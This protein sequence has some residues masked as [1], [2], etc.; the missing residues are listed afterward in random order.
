MLSWLTYRILAYVAGGLGVAVIGLSV[1]L[2]AQGIRSDA[3]LAKKDRDHAQA[4]GKIIKERDDATQKVRA[5]EKLMVDRANQANEKYTK[6]L[7]AKDII[8]AGL[9]SAESHHR[10]TA[11]ELRR[12]LARYVASRPANNP[13]CPS[14][15]RPA[16]LGNLLD[17]AIGITEGLATVARESTEA[18]E[19]H[20]GEVRTLKLYA[21][22]VCRVQ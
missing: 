16:A 4:I 22:T 10:A 2:W 6:E 5:T 18:A 21:Q 11:V 8:I 13:A 14:D 1:A 15:P 19:R 7:D 20:A 17:E 3:A 12:D 9:R